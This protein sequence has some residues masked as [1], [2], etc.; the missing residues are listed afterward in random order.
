MER[1][2]R[3]GKSDSQLSNTQVDMNSISCNLDLQVP[4]D[5]SGK[6]LSIVKSGKAK[7]YHIL[8]T[9]KF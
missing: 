3:K 4:I 9:I 5:K 2:S 7:F 6:K 8:N 1:I